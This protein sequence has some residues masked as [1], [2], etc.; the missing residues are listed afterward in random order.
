MT[1]AEAMNIIRYSS[2]G[3]A[4]EKKNNLTE[5]RG[6]ADDCQQSHDNCGL[7]GLKSLT[8]KG[9]NAKIPPF[10]LDGFLKQKENTCV[11]KKLEV[12]FF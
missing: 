3:L 11:N 4:Q 2:P 10:F 1:T 12:V 9:P 8:Q 5:L 7:F 6:D